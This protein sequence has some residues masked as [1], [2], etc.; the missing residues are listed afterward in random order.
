MS[1]FALHAPST[2]FALASGSGKSAVAIFRLSG[3]GTAG[4]LENL[5]GA[6]PDARTASLRKIRDERGE[7]LD[8][9]LVLWFP[10]PSS[11]T[12]EDAAELHIHGSRAVIAALYQRLSNV[13]GC[14]PA[15]PG[16][17]T[18]RAFLNGRMDLTAV[19]GLADLIDSETE[20][21]RRQALRQLDGPLGRQAELWRRML[22]ELLAQIEAEI[23]FSDVDDVDAFDG[24]RFIQ[25]AQELSQDLK[26]A[27][28]F[29]DRG[30]KV[31]SGFVVVLAGPPNAGKSSLLNALTRRDIAIVSAIPGTTR[32]SIEAHLDIDGLPVTVIDT[33]GIREARDEIEQEGVKRA[34]ARAAKADLVIWLSAEGAPPDE[35]L[36][37]TPVVLVRSKSDLGNVAEG[38]S[39]SA[40]TGAGIEALL[41]LLAAGAAEAS[42]GGETALVVRERHR[43]LIAEA[44]TALQRSIDAVSGSRPALELAGEDLRIAASALGRVSGRI[45]VEDVLG[46]IFS[47]FCIGK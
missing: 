38:L 15:E 22:L 18:R 28:Q 29:A 32:D 4:V 37:S 41:G 24:G 3:R 35:N 43:R 8:Q 12:G 13:A 16:E 31:R 23:D 40:K 10:G 1:Q 44:A 6:L 46:E 21:Q 9:G 5:C 47:R 14:R 26:S 36:G 42:A 17:F 34:L 19:E 20:G 2:I 7:I 33:A 25:G 27:L 30:E 11:F 45:D 39:V